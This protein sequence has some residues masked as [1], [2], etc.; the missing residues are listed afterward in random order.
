MGYV[1]VYGKG[2][3]RGSSRLVNMLWQQLGLILLK[4][5][6]NCVNQVKMHCLSTIGADA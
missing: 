6:H 5:G 2:R 4:R 3:R 1:R